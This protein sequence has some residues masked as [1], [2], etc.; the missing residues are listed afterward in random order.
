MKES[1]AVSSLREAIRLSG[2]KDGMCVSFH[3][4]QR[5]GD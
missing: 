1:K 2:L 4:N 5:N 3:T